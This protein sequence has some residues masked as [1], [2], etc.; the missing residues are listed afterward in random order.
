LCAV[1]RG[2]TEQGPRAFLNLFIVVE[3]GDHHAT[4]LE[5]NRLVPI[6]VIP[7]QDDPGHSSRVSAVY[8]APPRHSFVAA[9]KDIPELWEIP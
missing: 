4:V 1:G 9:L 5:G 6:K 8:N 2:C 7:V 3:L